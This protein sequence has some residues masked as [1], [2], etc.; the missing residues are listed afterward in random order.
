MAPSAALAGVVEDLSGPGRGFPGATKD[1][2]E[3]LLDTQRRLISRAE[4]LRLAAIRALI[5]A[6]PAPGATRS[7]PGGLPSMWAEDLAHEVAPLLHISLQAADKQI[8]LAWEL[9][10]RLPGTGKLLDD[11]EIEIPLALAVT[12]ELSVLNDEQAR[13][14]ELRILD[15]LPGL[16]PGKARRLAQQAAVTTDPDGARK[17]RE[18]AEKDDARVEFYASHT[19]TYRLF[20]AGLPTAEALTADRTINA[21]AR[22]YKKADLYP[23]ASM[24]N[25]RAMALLD[26]VNGITLTQRAAMARE[27]TNAGPDDGAGHGSQDGSGSGSGPDDGDGAPGG[28]DPENGDPGHGGDVPSGRPGGSSDPKDSGL[29]ANVN[30]TLPLITLQGLGERPGQVPGHGAIDPALARILAGQAAA[31]ARSSFCLSLT[32]PE[33][34]AIGHGCARPV[35][36]N[37]RKRANGTGSR[38][39]P[40]VP[41]TLTRLDHPGPPGGYGSWLLSLPGG[42]Q[43][44]LDLHAVP[45]TDCGHQHA[46]SAYRPGKLLRHLI[47]IRDGE[48]THPS[49]S[50]PAAQCDFEHAVPYDKGGRTCGCNAG[51]RSRRCHRVKQMPGWE[52]TQPKPGWHQWRTPTGRTYTQG[53]KKYPA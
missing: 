32:S 25:L 4:A 2:L 8:A 48:C 21:R 10:A 23:G 3:G 22:Q 20:A 16:T 6:N 47:E 30:L 1:E 28:S 40:P 50:H 12:D 52:L 14:A 13:Q 18:Q 15:R 42:G 33:G 11:G 37:R 7:A 41:W 5:R 27:E 26:L 38:D 49:C 44:L 51:A 53:P 24:D 46:T 17:R 34:H 45:L 9:E 39:G 29:P 19:G 43:L 31:S 36:K 35:P